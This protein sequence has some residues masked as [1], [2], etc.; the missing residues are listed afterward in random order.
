MIVRETSGSIC[1]MKMN[2]GANLVKVPTR[3]FI[4]EVQETSTCLKNLVKV[5]NLDKVALFYFFP[6]H[7]ATIFS[8]SVICCR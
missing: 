3:V 4:I 8:V 6:F 2:E 1:L 5:Q 7:S